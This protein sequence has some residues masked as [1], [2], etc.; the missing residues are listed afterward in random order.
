MPM[1]RKTGPPIRT[2]NSV[3]TDPFSEGESKSWEGCL[4]G[5]NQPVKHGFKYGSSVRI[6]SI[7][8]STSRLDN[9]V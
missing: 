5:A 7:S 1:R 8:G 6:F 2:A 4:V 3:L 9:T